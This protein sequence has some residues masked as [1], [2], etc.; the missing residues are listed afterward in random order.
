MEEE[1]RLIKCFRCGK[2]GHIAKNCIFEQEK[3]KCM[4]CLED[5]HHH[6]CNSRACFRCNEI[7]HVAQVYYT[8]FRNAQLLELSVIDVERRGTLSAIAEQLSFWIIVSLLLTDSSEID[9]R[10][11]ILKN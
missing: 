9:L 2:R 5:H 7:G 3:D 8:L 1:K 11:K 10:L 6:D 4:Y